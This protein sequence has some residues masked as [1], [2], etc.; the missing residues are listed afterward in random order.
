MAST[1]EDH[2]NTIT[3][4]ELLEHS[5]TKRS[6]DEVTDYSSEHINTFTLAANESMLAGKTI[7]RSIITEEEKEAN[8]EFFVGKASR[9]PENYMCIRNYILDTWVKRQPNYVS[10]TSVRPALKHY[11][12]MNTIGRVHAYLEKIGAINKDCSI[13][14]AVRTR[15]Q[16]KRKPSDCED[17]EK[18]N[19]DDFEDM[20]R[21]RRR[22]IIDERDEDIFSRDSPMADTDGKDHIRASY[23]WHLSPMRFNR[24]FLKTKQVAERENFDGNGEHPFRLISP[25][26]Y[27]AF[28]PPPFQIEIVSNAKLVMDFHAHMTYNEIIGL[29]GGKYDDKRRVLKIF[30][31][32]PCQGTSTGIECE[33][34]PVSEMHANEAFAARGFDVVGWYHS[35]PTFDPQPSLRDIENQAQYQELFRHED[36]VEPFIGIIITPYDKLK[37]SNVSQFQF[38]FVGP[39]LEPLGSHRLPYTCDADTIRNDTL[40]DEVFAQL[41]EIV[42]DFQDSA[43]RVNMWDVYRAKESTLRLDKFIES[44]TAHLFLSPDEQQ[45]YLDRIREMVEIE[46][47]ENGENSSGSNRQSDDSN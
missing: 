6:Q 14:T 16:L 37:P 44:L 13:A 9:T 23:T 15:S 24:T 4:A 34:D 20:I 10:K 5:A 25:N 21:K 28:N 39:D 11:G 31:A 33:M 12:D 8:K 43:N 45:C 36:G 35:H 38:I 32:F 1:M 27:D 40:S 7:D 29:L 3:T 46:F 30:M 2:I 41:V 42:R 47:S 19:D 18:L 26:T 17:R 22:S